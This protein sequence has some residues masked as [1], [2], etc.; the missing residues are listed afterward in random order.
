MAM[1]PQER[2]DPD[3]LIIVLIGA[4]A[5]GKSSIAERLCESGVAE[6]TPTWT[7]RPPRDGEANTAYDHHFVSDDEFDAQSRKGAFL[8]ERELYG[9]RYGVPLL[10]RP[11]EGREAL[12]VLKPLFME[13][14]LELFPAT[15]IYQIEASPEILPERMRTRGQSED[16]ITRRMGLHEAESAEARRYAHAVF[17]NDAALEL[18]VGMVEDQ[19]AADRERHAGS[20]ALV[21]A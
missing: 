11:P 7:T 9:F 2:L 16:D 3:S 14:F 17:S 15:R 5:V 10:S 8:D 19:I 13:K 21:N 18:T 6:A 1:G 4:S 20:H 12:M